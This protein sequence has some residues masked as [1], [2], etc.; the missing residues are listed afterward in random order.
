MEK[1][2]KC[3]YESKCTTNTITLK[4]LYD[5]NYLKDKIVN[6]YDKTIYSDNNKRGFYFVSEVEP[7]FLFLPIIAATMVIINKAK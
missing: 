1:A 6:P 4:M 2:E 3:I 7:S 5:L